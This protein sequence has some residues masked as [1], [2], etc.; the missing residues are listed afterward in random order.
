MADAIGLTPD[1]VA[2]K[3][4]QEIKDVLYGRITYRNMKTFR[5]FFVVNAQDSF[6]ADYPVYVPFNIPGAVAEVVSVHVSFWLLPFRAYSKAAK[7]GG[8]QTSGA[9]STSTTP[10]GGGTT[11][12]SGG[13]T[14]SSSGGG[15]TS[16]AGSEQTTVVASI[17]LVDEGTFYGISKDE[18]YTTRKVATYDHTHSVK[19]HTHSCPDH[20]H[21]CL[22]HTHTC[23]SHQ[24]DITHTHKTPDHEHEIDYGIYEKTPTSPTIDIYF[25]NNDADFDIFLGSYSAD[26]YIEFGTRLKGTGWKAIKFECNELMRIQSLIRIKSDIAVT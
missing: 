1:E 3:T 13:G 2:A 26:G 24:H 18:T 25:S 19:N 22:N 5:T 15:Q 20:Q 21:A 8:S 11:T 23:P 12:P 4:V 14:T 16:G 10:S 17:V 6:D 7:S 9:S